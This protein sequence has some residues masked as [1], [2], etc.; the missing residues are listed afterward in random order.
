MKLPQVDIVEACAS[1]EL[2]N[3]PLSLGQRTFL[4]AMDGLE[5]SQEE[6]DLFCST[7]GRTS[8]KPGRYYREAAL[9]AGR[10]F[11][12]THHI[13]VPTVVYSAVF[14][15]FESTRP[16][17][18][19]M[20]LILATTIPQAAVDFSGILGVLEGS[21][22]CRS[23]IV[24]VKQK[25]VSLRTGHDIAAW[26]NDL[27]TVRNL[28]IGCC[29]A[30]ECSFWLDELNGTVNPAEEI[31]AAVR[32]ALMQFEY[33]RLLL[34]SSPWAKSGPIWDAWA[35][36]LEREEPLVL[37]MST[38]QGN[39]VLSAERLEAER[40]RD[41]ER[42]R[43]ELDAEFLDSASA[44]LPSDAV[45]AC[46]AMGR[47]EVAPKEHAFYFAAIDAGF[48][49][50]QFAFALAHAE[51]A[52]VI[53]DLVRAWRPQPG[54]AVQFQPVM[55]EIVEVMRRYGAWQAS[56]DQVCNEVIKQYLAQEGVELEQVTTLGRRASG[57]YST[58]R[59]KVLAGEVEFPDNP[60]LLG[61]LK[62]LQ[63]VVS[64]GGHERCEASSGKDDMAICT[65]LAVHQVVGEP[66]EHE[67]IFEA[68]TAIPPPPKPITP[69]AAALDPF[70]PGPERWWRE[71]S[72]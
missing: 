70:D 16:G 63:I 21:P 57:I 6:V 62:R 39:P 52:K 20:D 51:G 11:G 22:L 60:A 35:R 24:S 56:A 40:A 53:V 28:A 44:L 72:R 9:I 15:E 19:I 32:P 30:E 5:M 59:T 18:R 58:L 65:A 68:M 8:Y 17:E 37:R 61:Q 14:R 49:T 31:L 36:R 29:V 41:P 26:K 4:K 48:R 33:G 25:R 10:R 23:L 50:D 67:L 64:G 7:S 47:W 42:A 46:T 38:A 12:K 43:R 45:D 66:S 2:L 1:E 55:E 27:R 13:A 69:E 71:F 54:R 3:I 34:V